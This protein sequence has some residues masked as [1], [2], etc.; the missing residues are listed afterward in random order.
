MGNIDVVGT[1]NTAGIT[2]RTDPN[3]FGGKD[4]VPVAVLDM[5]ED[6][7]GKNVHGIGD[8]TPC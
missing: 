5:T 3:C 2:G 1:S 4:F 8:G 6:L 7:I